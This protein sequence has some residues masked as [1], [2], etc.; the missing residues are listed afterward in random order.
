MLKVGALRISYVVTFVLVLILSL[1]LNVTFLAIISLKTD[2]HASFFFY[3]FI[4]DAG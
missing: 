1:F 3:I 4:I 2:I